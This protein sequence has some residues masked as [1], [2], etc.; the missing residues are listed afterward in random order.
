MAGDLTFR[1]DPRRLA[2]ENPRVSGGVQGGE[3]GGGALSGPQSE[4]RRLAGGG[5]SRWTASEHRPLVRCC[6]RCCHCCCFLSNVRNANSG[7]DTI[8][9]RLIL[10]P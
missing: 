10:A 4:G 6:C 7:L 9:G 1:L 8:T 3:A 2:D 5:G